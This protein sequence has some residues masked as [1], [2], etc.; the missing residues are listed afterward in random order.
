MAA[1]LLWQCQDGRTGW[2]FSDQPG[3]RIYRFHMRWKRD[4][5]AGLVGDLKWKRT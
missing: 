4:Y 1:I 2:S 5:V 3:A